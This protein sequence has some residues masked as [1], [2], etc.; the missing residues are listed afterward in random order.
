MLVMM[1]LVAWILFEALICK[2]RATGSLQLVI[3]GILHH[4]SLCDPQLLSG[5][6]QCTERISKAPIHV[7]MCTPCS[8]FLNTLR[9]WH[10]HRH[11]IT[12]WSGKRPVLS[13]ISWTRGGWLCILNWPSG[14]SICRSRFG[15]VWDS[16][17]FIR[18]SYGL[19][20]FTLKTKGRG[21]FEP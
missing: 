4:L 12:Q 21:L 18:D 14:D 13:K 5:L 19:S 17:T 3:R 15:S 11:N 9:S 7:W 10:K 16:P 20:G 1:T 8:S 6:S 2:H